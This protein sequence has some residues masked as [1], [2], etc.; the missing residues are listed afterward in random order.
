MSASRSRSCIADSRYIAEDAAALVDVDYD[1][2]PVVADCRKAI[3]AGAPAVRR[4]LNSNI[5]A[6]YKVNFGDPDAAFAKAAHVFHT[7]LWQHRGAGASDR[8]ARHRSPNT[9]AAPTASPSGP[10]PRRRTTCSSR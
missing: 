6:T 4:E 7:D 1:L 5:V 2:L 10:R 8:G 9:T 3:A